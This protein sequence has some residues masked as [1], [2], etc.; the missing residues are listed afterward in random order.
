[1]H[2]ES[3]AAVK[4]ALAI[5]HAA[6]TAS[7]IRKD[8]TGS[9]HISLK[10]TTA[11]LDRM[12]AEGEIFLWPG[13]RF[14]IRS[15][16]HEASRLILELLAGS[17]FRTAGKL[18]SALRLPL[19]VITPAL[20]QLVAEGRVHIWQPGKTAMYCLF[21]PQGAARE[22]IL[23]ALQIETLDEKGLIGRIRTRFP[24]YTAGLLREHLQ[25]LLLSGQVLEHPKYG[26]AKCRY[27]SV[28][29]DPSIYLEKAVSEIEAVHRVLAASGVSLERIFQ[30]LSR[31]LGLSGET[32][33]VTRE[34]PDGKKVSAE[35]EN[36]VLQGIIRLQPL[37]Q[38]RALVSIRELRRSLNMVKRDFDRA[39][40]SL[41][42]KGRV[43]LHHHDF[44]ASLRPSERE[45]M[46]QD[47]QGNYYVGIVP[48]EV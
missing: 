44:P 25:P 22:S 20:D 30:A 26:K 38:R 9:F 41:A 43:A 1:M 21:E 23:R 36:L 48:K 6:M 27:G 7:Q 10:D 13:K 28:P 24:G 29:P 47:E 5:S 8:L 35:T 32:S 15:P 17:P 19:E 31:S 45:E 2:Q 42:L 12:A 14:W 46:V 34:R 3:R 37:G 11:T 40:F 4:K 33:T 16:Q 18:K 39:V